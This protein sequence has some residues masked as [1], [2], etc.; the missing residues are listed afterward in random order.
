MNRHELHKFFKSLGP[1]VLPVIHVQSAEQAQRNVLVAAREG[2]HGVF[3]INHDFPPAQF[4]PIIEHVRAALPDLWLGVNFLAVTGLEAFPMLAKLADQGTY[5]DAYWADDACLD[6]GRALDAQSAAQQIDQARARSGWEGLYFGGTAFK[7]QRPVPADRYEDTAR[8]ATWYM[9]VVTTSGVATGEAPD[10]SKIDAFRT[11]CAD[12]PL[13][14]ASGITLENAHAY[15]SA[16][17]CVLVATGVNIDGDFYNIDATKL[18]RLLAVMRR[19]GV[20][21]TQ[22]PEHVTTDN[23]ETR[24]WYLALMAPNI[25]GERFAWLDPSAMYVNERSFH[26]LL[27]DLLAPFDPASIDVVG[28]LDA[29]GFVLGSAMATRLGKGFLTVRKAGKLPVEADTAEFTNYTKRTQ[30]MQMR[31][32]AFH[33]GTRVLLVDQWIETGGTMEGAIELVERQA[34][35]VA[36][37]AAVCIEENE[38]TDRLRERFL[39]SS[40]VRPGTAIQKQCNRQT[41]DSFS[42][43][44][45]EQSFPGKSA[46]KGS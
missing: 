11:G 20:G 13:A 34:G 28:G 10:L 5:V 33:P 25:R 39:C 12:H 3:L 46:K 29:M 35:M 1:A 9:D 30:Q 38:R 6:E 40:A 18:R 31:K 4:L 43:Y 23:D 32:P 37:I 8:L 21:P 24:P 19:T 44:T 15:A 16:V 22:E 17:D 27:D 45:P 2:A 42:T 36:G 14:L 7:K 26:A 41:L